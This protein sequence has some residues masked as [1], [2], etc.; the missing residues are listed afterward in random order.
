MKKHLKDIWNVENQL[1]AYPAILARNALDGYKNQLTI[2]G[3]AKAQ[4]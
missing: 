2:V 1:K 4:L 3:K